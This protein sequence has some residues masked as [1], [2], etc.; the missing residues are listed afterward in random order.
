MV[1][2]DRDGTEK[3]GAV[4]APPYV[5]YKTFKNF[6][7][8]LH[9]A[10]PGR[11]DRS[12]MHTMSG[13]AQG[14][15]MQALRTMDLVS[16][17]GIPTERFIRLATGSDEQHR[18]A[19][20]SAL[21]S[22]YPFLFSGSIDLAT[23]TGKQLLEQFQST[24]LSGDTVRRSVSFF[25]AAAK[26]AGISLSPY[27]DKIQSRSGGKRNGGGASDEGHPKPRKTPRRTNDPGG[28]TP[29]SNPRDEPI[30]AQKSLLL[31][32][33]FQRLPAP[34]TVWPTPQRDQWIQT[35]Q[36]VFSLEY[37]DED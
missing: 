2:T 26:D 18:E 6:M 19:L 4:I 3:E 16:Q 15:M 12:V 21:R 20:T 5:P 33:L 29:L 7:E 10:V 37:R 23:A 34:G 30:P 27:F 9:A 13:G 14:Q 24:S 22:G 36:N 8:S 17:H 11:I 1:T 31:W 25:L 32:G 35:L 28:D